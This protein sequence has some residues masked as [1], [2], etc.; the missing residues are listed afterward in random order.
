MV[1]KL[2]SKGYRKERKI[3]NYFISKGL[4]AFRSAGSHSPIDCVAI[5]T[6]KKE[7]Y[8]IQCKSGSSY[9]LKYKEKLNNELSSFDGNYLVNFS[10]V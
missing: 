10:V 7:I 6:I 9:S 4:I 5:D 3:V 8:M 2:Y 1:N